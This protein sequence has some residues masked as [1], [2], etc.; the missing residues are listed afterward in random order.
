MNAVTSCLILVCATL[1]SRIFAV[2]VVDF[3][4]QVCIEIMI[5]AEQE[6]QCSFGQRFIRDIR[7]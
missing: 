7:E 1:T 3:D 4:G 6:L 5:K 2:V